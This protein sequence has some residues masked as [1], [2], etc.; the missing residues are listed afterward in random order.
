WPCIEGPDRLPGFNNGLEACT[1][2][3]T[4]AT[5]APWYAFRHLQDLYQGDPCRVITGSGIAGIAFYP[6]GTYPGEYEGALFFADYSRSCVYVMKT[7]ATGMPDPATRTAFLTHRSNA[8]QI[9]APHPVDLQIGPG[10]DLFL[11]D[12]DG[13]M[14]RRIKY[15][16]GNA[17]P[18]AAI[19][20]QPSQ[21]PVPLDV[22]FDAA[23]STDPDPGATLFY[24]WD[25]DGDG[26]YD[27]A[28][29]PQATRTY[30]V[31]GD[32][33]VGLR[34]TDDDGATAFATR[35]VSPGN[36]HPVAA[37]DLPDPALTWHVGEAIPFSG[38]ATDTTDG[39]LAPAA[40]VWDFILRHCPGGIGECHDH[41]IE[42]FPGVD[43]GVV[44]A[45]DHEYYSELELRLTVTDSGGLTDSATVVLQPKVVTDSFATTP[46]GLTL[47]AG[48][49]PGITPFDRPT[50]VGS[51]NSLVVPTPQT[52]DGTGWYFV[53]WDDGGAPGRSYVALD[54][55]QTL[56]ATFA[57]CLGSENV[58]DGVDEDCNGFTDDVPLPVSVPEVTV[59]SLLLTLVAVPDATGYDVVYGRLGDP[60]GTPFTAAATLGCVAAA[61]P[62]GSLDFPG[63]PA[64]GEGFW[65]VARARGCAGPAS[66]DSGDPEQSDSRDAE[67]DAAPNGCPHVAP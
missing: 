13:G 41:A 48:T 15:N 25:L 7:D 40:F 39:L 44:T 42:T 35:V 65:F 3:P 11:V 23:G 66:Y 10:S 46:P 52:L 1:T 14:V 32:V 63:D 5:E 47:L 33:T 67:L 61:A 34:V 4:T 29:L 54:T 22:A 59:D 21:G 49:E 56:H 64:P 28:F 60:N 2:L 16:T 9:G 20:A 50:I 43:L 37:I 19:D 55:P 6:W 36:A 57:A 51:L 8:Q 12:Y 24:A 38:S 45:P 17:P 31:I 26:E 30:D 62:A 18:V 58:C 53:A 27:D